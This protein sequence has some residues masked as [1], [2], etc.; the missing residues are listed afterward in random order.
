MPGVP[1]VTSYGAFQ[2]TINKLVQYRGSY[3]TRA[4]ELIG[5]VKTHLQNALDAYVHSSKS[6]YEWCGVAQE[7]L[8]SYLQ[9]LQNYDK[10]KATQQHQIIIH[11][12]EDDIAKVISAQSQLDQASRTFNKVSGS[13]ST[14]VVLSND[15]EESKKFPQEVKGALVNADEKIAETKAKLKDEIQAL[16]DVKST[17]YVVLDFINAVKD[18]EDFDDV[19][20]HEIKL[21]VEKL[22]EE[23]GKYRERYNG[24]R[25]SFPQ[26]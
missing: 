12:L 21:S 20:R 22:I 14:V 26:N 1:P 4:A 25:D 9:F 16:G 7:R 13:I 5:E 6:A 19:I 23:C 24:D 15:D 18:S 2:D 17:A 10:G 8:Q 11:E 3:S